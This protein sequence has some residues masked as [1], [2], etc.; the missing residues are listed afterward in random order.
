MSQQIKLRYLCVLFFLPLVWDLVLPQS[1]IL[2][3]FS[4]GCFVPVT[5]TFLHLWR[6][7]WIAS[8]AYDITEGDVTGID[9][10]LHAL[11][12]WPA[13]VHAFKA[14][15]GG[16]LM[17]DRTLPKLESDSLLY[18]LSVRKRNTTTLVIYLNCDLIPV[19]QSET[20]YW[21]Q[22]HLPRRQS[23]KVGW[24]K[25]KWQ[26]C[27]MWPLSLHLSYSQHEALH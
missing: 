1:Q 8:P 17:D 14:L 16:S 21:S 26:R 20:M 18:V 5:L 6:S 25:R 22:C 3:W 2:H 12:M 13:T 15:V 11:A 24:S 10:Y 9:F 23:K 4:E 19:L 27:H 7:E